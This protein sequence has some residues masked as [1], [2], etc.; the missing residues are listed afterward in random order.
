MKPPNTYSVLE[1]AVA[2]KT[3]E[4]SVLELIAT[5]KL[6]PINTSRGTKRPRWAI[7]IEQVDAYGKPNHPQPMKIPQHV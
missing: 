7:P 5:G 4:R 2:L 3:S 6:K 1:A